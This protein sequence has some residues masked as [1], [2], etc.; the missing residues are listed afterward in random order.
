MIS[1]KKTGGNFA[2]FETP[3]N[4]QDAG[5]RRS[6]RSHAARGLETPKASEQEEEEAEAE[7]AKR[8]VSQHV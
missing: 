4:K 2:N 8:E 5:L 1:H 6:P 7:A 3:R